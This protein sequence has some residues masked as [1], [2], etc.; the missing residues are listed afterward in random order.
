MAQRLEVQAASGGIH[1]AEGFSIN[2]LRLLTPLASFLAALLLSLLS[3]SPPLLVTP[4]L[5]SK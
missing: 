3:S 2:R 4:S 1:G 5:G